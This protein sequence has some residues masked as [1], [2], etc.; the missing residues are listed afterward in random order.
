MAQNPFSDPNYG[1]DIAAAA[2]KPANPFEDPEYGIEPTLGA[3]V[4]QGV[5]R[6]V[7]S[8][9]T[10]LTDDPAKIA[11]IASE[12]ARTAL[13]QTATQRKMAEE[14]APYVDEANMPRAWWTT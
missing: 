13:P 1:A 12:Q 7:D 8:A 5:G 3:R 11:K 2:G 9:R 6:A 4:K 14:F 10:A